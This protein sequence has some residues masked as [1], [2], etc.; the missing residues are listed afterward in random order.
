M[1][2]DYPKT[3]N[4]KD[5]E[6][7][8]LRTLQPGDEKRLSDFFSGLPLKDRLFL[9]HDV[10]D[11]ETIKSWV[12]TIDHEKIISIVALKGDQII[13]DATL[14]RNKFGWF[15]HVGEIRLVT[16]PDYRRK[17]LGVLLN[18]EIFFIALTLKLEKIIAMMVEDQ[19]AAVRVFTLLGF[20]KEAVLKDH[21]MDHKGNKRIADNALVALTLMIAVV[22]LRKK[23]QSPKLSSI[24]L[25]EKIESL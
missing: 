3:V 6:E 16:H 2:E 8:V 17:G 9:K 25:T 23:T 5:G 22:S 20:E 24:L 7:V 21:I 4:L 19:H 1:L 15:R 11:P 12:N 13:G 10:T 18:K 14:H